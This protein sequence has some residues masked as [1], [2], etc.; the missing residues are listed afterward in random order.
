[1]FKYFYFNKNNFTVPVL[2]APYGFSNRSFYSTLPNIR[3]YRHSYYNVVHLPSISDSCFD[4]KYLQFIKTLD[5]KY[6][7]LLFFYTYLTSEEDLKRRGLCHISKGCYLCYHIQ[8]TTSLNNLT[9]IRSIKE[10]FKEKQLHLLDED[11]SNPLEL[12]AVNRWINSNEIIFIKVFN[13]GLLDYIKTN[14]IRIDIPD[15]NSEYW[16]DLGGNDREIY[17]TDSSKPI[18]LLDNDPVI[19]NPSKALIYLGDGIIVID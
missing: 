9:T 3:H 17:T 14:S 7:Y 4:D 19:I 6:Y 18:P 12:P 1:M 2:S 11:Y 5:D 15:E 8:K 13:L 16:L 10:S